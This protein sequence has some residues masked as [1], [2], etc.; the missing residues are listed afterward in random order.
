MGTAFSL[1][2]L[3]AVDWLRTLPDASIDLVVTDPPYE[4]LEKHRKIGTTTRLKDSKASS[5]KW[6]EIFP[7]ERF[8]EL[9]DEH[10]NSG[11][12]RR[13]LFT[14][15]RGRSLMIRRSLAVV[16]E[17]VLELAP[18]ASTRLQFDDQAMRDACLCYAKRFSVDSSTTT[19]ALDAPWT[20]PGT[21]RRERI[22]MNQY[23]CDH[24]LEAKSR[25]KDNE[26]FVVVAPEP[27]DQNGIAGTSA[28]RQFQ[29]PS[30]VPTRDSCCLHRKG[31]A[32]HG[33]ANPHH[34]A[35]SAAWFVAAL[36]RLAEPAFARALVGMQP[37]RL[38]I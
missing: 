23:L 35:V 24:L 5:N 12:V 14:F 22:R 18:G 19:V 38:A 11:P 26:L 31:P 25:A 6:F 15:R 3:D 28:K 16:L 27:I 32:R 21:W 1:Y 17:S 8:P 4:S 20:D 13:R 33:P 30:N 36:A 37:K 10:F 2:N 7:N 9:F 29:Q 34:L